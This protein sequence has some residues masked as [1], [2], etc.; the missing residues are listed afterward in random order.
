[1]LPQEL[2]EKDKHLFLELDKFSVTLRKSAEKFIDFLILNH[3]QSPEMKSLM[4]SLEHIT[5]FSIEDMDKAIEELKNSLA[6]LN[7]YAKNFDKLMKENE[8]VEFMK[9]CEE[10]GINAADLAQ[11]AIELNE[12]QH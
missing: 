9:Y 1:M 3:K 5:A 2:D 6:E 12:Q 10:M 7:G 11:K 8:F 4:S